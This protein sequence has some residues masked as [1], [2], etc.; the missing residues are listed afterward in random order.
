MYRKLN[1]L[2]KDVARKEDQLIRTLLVET[3]DK[4]NIGRRVFR[5]RRVI[6]RRGYDQSQETRNRPVGKKTGLTWY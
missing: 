3:V 4:I 5:A 1:Y 6:T 2:K